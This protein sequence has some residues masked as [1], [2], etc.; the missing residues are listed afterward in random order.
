MLPFRIYRS[1]GGKAALS[2]RLTRATRSFSIYNKPQQI[3]Q[4]THTPPSSTLSSS[5][6]STQPLELIGNSNIK[7]DASEL[8]GYGFHMPQTVKASVMKFMCSDGTTKSDDT[9]IDVTDIPDA[10]DPF[11]DE[12]S[13]SETD[14]DEDLL[15]E[16]GAAQMNPKEIVG[17]LDRFIVGQ[18]D[19]KKAI[20]LALRNRWRRKKLPEDI[21]DEIMPKNILMIGPTGVGKTEIARRLAKLAHAPFIKVE[22]TKFTEVGFHGKDVDS[23]I[24]DLTEISLNMTKV[25][26][27]Q[28]LKKLIDRNVEKRILDELCGKSQDKRMFR[29]FREHYR[30]GTLDD[31]TITID[32]PVRDAEVRKMY[33]KDTASA[34]IL[35][36]ELGLHK[37]AEKRRLKI[38]DC[39]PLL[40]DI[41]TEK[42]VNTDDVTKEAVEAVQQDGIVFLD[43][44]DKIC[45]NSD[46]IHSADAS[47][48]G[49]QRD[50][51]PLIEGSTINT[52]YGN[53]D[54][55]YILFVAS[56]AFHSCKPSDLL[57]ELQGR[58]PI[59]VQ[60][61][62]L[63]EDD[64]YKILTEPETNLIKQQ[65]ALMST[66]DV[67]LVYD[68][69]AIREIAKVAHEVNTSVENIGARRL[70]TVIE[71]IMEEVS[72]ESAENKGKTI[73]ID[74]EYVRSK[75]SV[76]LK[77]HDLQ[78]YVL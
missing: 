38:S 3:D 62:A 48:E 12:I 67:D 17:E 75:V 56:G 71:K 30:N 15:E 33:P 31:Q 51:L 26:K 68:D 16:E 6:D 1:V 27:R 58:L 5:H 76:L 4:I 10:S 18:E 40:E 36:K 14:F 32:V 11:N 66:E 73:T 70:H 53:V 25:K 34:I 45:S 35:N 2:T 21:K 78:R 74:D 9:P 29:N 22:A 65:I 23:I 72:F 46:R 77:K 8:Q 13:E 69:T 41:E 57:A 28:R 44:I 7:W 43:E 19:A 20:A 52:K 50:L 47:S 39:R 42:L 54:T 63:T 61:Q 59:R 64:L 24:K 49:V 60:L 55:D 37:S